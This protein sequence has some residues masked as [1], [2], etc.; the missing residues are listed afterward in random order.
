MK[1]LSTLR[2]TFQRSGSGL[3][4]KG[5][6]C[7]YSNHQKSSVHGNIGIMYIQANQKHPPKFDYPL[8]ANHVFLIHNSKSIFNLVP[9]SKDTTSPAPV[10][11]VGAE[12][13]FHLLIYRNL[14]TE[15]LVAFPQ[16]CIITNR[17]SNEC[18]N[19]L[20]LHWDM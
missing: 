14:Y 1:V 9:P 13:V 6:H 10:G 20:S 19:I 8:I 12:V 3:C 18:L 2:C 11:K 4:S 5:S 7:K 15:H 17:L 16:G